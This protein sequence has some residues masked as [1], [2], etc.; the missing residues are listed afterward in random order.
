MY[1]SCLCERRLS[2]CGAHKGV[3]LVFV[4]IS[5]CLTTGTLSLALGWTEGLGMAAAWL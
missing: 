2:L 5:S 1:Y 3:L 4:L